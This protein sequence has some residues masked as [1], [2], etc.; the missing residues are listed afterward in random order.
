MKTILFLCTGNYY[1]SRYAEELFNHHA[2]R[3]GLSWIAQSRGLALERGMHNIGPISPYA[4]AALTQRGLIACGGERLPQQ[5]VA[6]DFEA[7]AH[8]VALSESEHRPLLRA[9]FPEWESRI[10]YWEVADVEITP[11]RIALGSI[12]GQI[13]LLLNRLRI[14]GAPTKRPSGG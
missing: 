12:D 14:P 9:R 7:A 6:A 13:E 10:E 11:P 5:C 2:P 3:A 1:R 4:L 8:V